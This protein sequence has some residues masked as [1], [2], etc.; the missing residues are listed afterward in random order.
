[1][2]RTVD[3]PARIGACV[4]LIF[5]APLPGWAAVNVPSSLRQALEKGQAQDVIVEF[6]DRTIQVQATNRKASAG[7]A[8]ESDAILAE[9]VRAYAALKSAVWVGKTDVSVVRDYSHLPMVHARVQSLAALDAIAADA[10]VSNIFANEEKTSTLTQS[11]PLVNQ[12]LAAAAGASAAGTTVAVLDSGV[13]YTLPAF[14]SCTT[15][16]VPSGCR[17][18]AAPLDDCSHGTN[19]S[20]IVAA[21][22]PGVRIAAYDVAE[23]C[24][25]PAT[26]AWTTHDTTVIAGI[27]WAIQ[28]R[29]TY[30][31]VAINMSLGSNTLYSQPCSTAYSTPVIQARNAGIVVVASSGNSAST[32]SMGAPACTPGVISVGAVHDS[33]GG[34]SGASCFDVT[35]TPDQV[36][37]FSNST[38]FLSMLA[39][40]VTIN[41]AGLTGTGTS[42]A[43]PHVAG[44]AAIMRKLFASESVDSV[45]DRL[46]RGGKPTLDQRTG[47]SFPRLDVYASMLSNDAFANRRALSG[48]T[49]RAQVHNRIATLELGEPAHAGVTGGRSVWWTWNAPSNGSVTINTRGSSVDTVL[50]VYTG[51]QVQS[52]VL[53]AQNDNAGGGTSASSVSFQAVSGT[54]YQI[55]VD[56]AGG[57]EGTIVLNWSALSWLSPILQLILE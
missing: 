20:A 19:V 47:Q 16:G 23:T 25:N 15:P 9:K 51:S 10:R 44:A 37:C 38:S 55:A 36:A 1:M 57:T 28:N 22:A 52:L 4:A 18:V 50:A 39:P 8:V 53:V 42:M 5:A 54:E 6:D 33:S 31:I 41:A 14:G 12:P 45:T 48:F 40:G 21:L 11:L 27:N 30:N 34:V 46:V 13:N 26:W 56:T 35:S 24:T 3:L 17:V 29:A 2:S 49:G 7:L 43:A 32:S